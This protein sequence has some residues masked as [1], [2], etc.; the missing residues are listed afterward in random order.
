[1]E[2][3]ELEDFR[4]Q[5]GEEMERRGSRWQFKEGRGLMH[6]DM[7][8]IPTLSLKQIL[9]KLNVLHTVRDGGGGLRY[10]IMELNLCQGGPW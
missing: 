4:R 5:G 3:K 9:L 1:M 6:L 2:G 8:P 10:A 7:T